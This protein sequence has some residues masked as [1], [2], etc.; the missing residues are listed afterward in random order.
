[1]DPLPPPAELPR[2]QRL[3]LPGGMLDAPE[4]ARRGRTARDWLVDVVM[5]LVAITLSSMALVDTWDDHSDVMKVV[6]IALGV[7]A[8]V[9]IWRRREHPVG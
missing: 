7:V 3:L 2:W 6:D 4:G 1:M 9:V 5:Y 8:L